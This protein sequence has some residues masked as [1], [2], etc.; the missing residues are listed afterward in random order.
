MIPIESRSDWHRSSPPTPTKGHRLIRHSF[1]PG[2]NLRV[3]LARAC[4][5]GCSVKHRRGTGEV[6][7]RHPSIP[8]TLRINSRRKDTPRCLTV[9]LR[10]LAES[11]R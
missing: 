7:V 2:E 1:S 10:R 8:T 4:E 9:L 3:S 6:L 11:S 5:C